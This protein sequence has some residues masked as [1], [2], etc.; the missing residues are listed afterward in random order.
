MKQ[1][2]LPT[3]KLMAGHGISMSRQQAFPAHDYV[4]T[5]GG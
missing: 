4:F 2:E 1:D 5:T 3:I